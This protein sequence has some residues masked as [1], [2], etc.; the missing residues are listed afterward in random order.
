MEEGDL[1]TSCGCELI[2][3][4]SPELAFV[5]LC[6]A[7]A[8]V[9]PLDP[10]GTGTP[11][12]H[13]VHGTVLCPHLRVDPN[14]PVGFDPRAAVRCSSHH[15]CAKRRRWL[16]EVA[17]RNVAEHAYGGGVDWY[18]FQSDA[19]LLAAKAP[20]QVEAEMRSWLV[21]HAARS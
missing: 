19:E 5:L 3:R 12:P 18:G 2:D 6:A 11:H 7:V 4:A 8:Y 9:P 13:D 17:H 10:T 1:A 21:L 16:N 14:D 15:D 20:A